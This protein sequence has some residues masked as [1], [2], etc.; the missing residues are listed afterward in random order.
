MTQKHIT[1]LTV[2][3]LMLAACK[4]NK[5]KAT[6]NV[7]P[8]V[9]PDTVTH[10]MPGCNFPDS[11]QAWNSLITFN[12]HREPCDSMPVVTDQYGTKFKDNIFVLSIQKNGQRFFHRLFS[13]NDFLNFLEQDFRE[14]G[15][16]DGFRCI[17]YEEGKL[18]FGTCVSYPES[19]MSQPFL[20]KIAQDG[21]YSVEED[22]TPIN[23][24]P[25]EDPVEEEDGI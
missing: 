20:I 11:L 22:H 15:M 12:I 1:I 25:A 19:D 4:E 17:G 24:N 14:H 6:I 2:I 18:T 10:S 23:E 16:F 3:A 5:D 9:E 7:L 13:K 21:T 8:E